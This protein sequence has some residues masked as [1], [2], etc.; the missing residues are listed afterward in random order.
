KLES[1]AYPE[2]GLQCDDHQVNTHI[3]S[4]D[5][6]VIYIEHFLSPFEADE[7]IRI[8]APHFTPST[9]FTG[10]TEKFDPSVRNSSKAQ[11]PR[12]NLVKC[13]ESR[14]REFQG[15]PRDTF[16]ERLWAQ[17]YGTGGHYVHHY[18]WGHAGGRHSGRRDSSFMVYLNGGSEEELQGGGTNFPRLEPPKMDD[19]N[20]V[21]ARRWCKFI[22]CEGEK[23]VAASKVVDGVTFKPIKGNAVFWQNFRSDGSGYEESFHAGLPVTAGEKYGLNIWSY[24]HPGHRPKV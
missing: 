7:I 17:R 5:P 14:A 19:A 6:L 21:E 3:L 12:T 22:E 11:I 18:D 15:W 1:L 10:G 16:I 20:S 8:S 2:S 24:R 9:T 13:I 23:T 4:K